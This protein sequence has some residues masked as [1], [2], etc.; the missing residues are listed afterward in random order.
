MSSSTSV[1]HTHAPAQ[2]TLVS[3][4]VLVRRYL[5]W[6]GPQKERQA[7]L[8]WLPANRAAVD[9]SLSVPLLGRKIGQREGWTMPYHIGSI[10]IYMYLTA[11][12]SSKQ[13]PR[14]AG[15]DAACDGLADGWTRHDIGLDARTAT[16]WIQ[17][18]GRAKELKPP[19]WW[20]RL[21]APINRA[22]RKWN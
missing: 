5:H 3:V 10:T 2:A 16:G 4:R 12:S 14:P 1:E 9:S 20:P 22:V 15:P 18:N 8:Q 21:F 17:N 13:A 6:Q 11:S 7:F 19:F